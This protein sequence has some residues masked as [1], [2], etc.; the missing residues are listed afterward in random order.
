MLALTKKTGYGLIALAHLAGLKEAQADGAVVVFSDV[1]FIS[2][3]MAYYQNP[4]KIEET[5]IFCTSSPK[6]WAA[7]AA[8]A[9]RRRIVLAMCDHELPE[10]FEDQL[11]TV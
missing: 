10:I 4:L 1:D 3:S 11:G 5:A 9:R 8:Q 2:N 6:P 7:P